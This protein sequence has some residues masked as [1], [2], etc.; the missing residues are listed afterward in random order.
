VKIQGVKKMLDLLFE[1]TIR[2]D[3]KVHI[4][5]LDQYEFEQL[6]DAKQ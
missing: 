5:I 2:F 4:T 3:N 1:V 6:V